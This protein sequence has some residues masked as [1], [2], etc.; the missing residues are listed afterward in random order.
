MDKQ[1][2]M[3]LTAGMDTAF[4]LSGTAIEADTQTL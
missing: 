4:S 1:R 3:T 2:L